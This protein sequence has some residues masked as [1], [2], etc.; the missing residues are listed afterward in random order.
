MGHARGHPHRD[1]EFPWTE[2]VWDPHKAQTV[3][4]PL[5]SERGQESKHRLAKIFLQQLERLLSFDLQI[6]FLFLFLFLTMLQ[7]ETSNNLNYK[8]TH[9]WV[10]GDFQQ[11]GSLGRPDPCQGCEVTQQWPMALETG[12]QRPPSEGRRANTPLPGQA[13]EEV[14]LTRGQ[15]A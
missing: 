8:N 13:Q 9:S 4:G 12:L 14:A 1:R 7:S 11:S 10:G 15:D 3:K 2:F 6:F 5:F